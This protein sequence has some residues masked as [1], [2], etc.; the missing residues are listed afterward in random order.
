MVKLSFHETDSPP[1]CA[2]DLQ[3]QTNLRGG[4]S[5]R[6][7]AVG[8]GLQ[9]AATAARNGGRRRARGADAGGAVVGQMRFAAFFCSA[10]G[11]LGGVQSQGRGHGEAGRR[12]RTS[13]GARGERK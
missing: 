6:G 3:R 10:R 1:P 13:G 5:T 2:A 12:S 9:D 7:P 11:Q 4:S 8:G